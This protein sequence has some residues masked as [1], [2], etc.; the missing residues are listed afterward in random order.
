MSP[1][2]SFACSV[3]YALLAIAVIAFERRRIRVRGPDVVS[4]FVGL[5]LAQCVFPGIV[6]YCLL[7][8]C[9]PSVQTNNIFFDRVYH[10]LNPPAALLVFGLTAW[11]FVFF[12]F[13]AKLGRRLLNFAPGNIPTGSAFVVSISICRLA[14]VLC[15][16]TVFTL[17]AF[18]LLGDSFIT[19]YVNL[20]QVRAHSEDTE[21][22]LLAS[23]SLSLTQTWGWLATLALFVVRDGTSR[24]WRWIL[25][26]CLV[27]VFAILGVSRR[28]IFI[29][30]ALYYFSALLYTSRWRVRLIAAGL[31]PVVAWVAFGKALLAAVAFGGTVDWSS[32]RYQ[33]LAEAGIRVSSEI[34]ITIVESLGSVSLLHIEPRFGVDHLLSIAHRIPARLLGF[35]LSFSERIVRVTTTVFAGSDEEDIPPGLFGQMWLD[36]GVFGPLFWGVLLGVQVSVIQY[37]YERVWRY[38]TATGLCALLV[39]V[40]ALPLNTGSYD[41]TFS[42]DMVTLACVLWLVARCELV[43]YTG[44]PEWALRPPSVEARGTG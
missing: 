20:I 7:P 33:S 24:R 34:G 31:V 5:F 35:D 18:W 27:I 4:V 9:T 13:G 38:R 43:R 40:V 12:H 29:P 44:T 1:G 23:Y 28:A 2:T 3:A 37:L 22:N 10:A 19:R 16:G 8:F 17:I 30:L 6:I 42:V 32:G 14:I 21:G 39:F 26:L 25:C 11:F 36:F 15:F 41:F